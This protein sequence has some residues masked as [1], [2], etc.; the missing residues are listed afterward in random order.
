M[1]LGEEERG[2]KTIGSLK[3]NINNTLWTIQPYFNI[4]GRI[5]GQFFRVHSIHL[6]GGSILMGIN[7]KRTGQREKKNKFTHC[8]NF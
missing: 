2:Q 1:Y 4:S 3:T 8:G 5:H 6:T 7:T